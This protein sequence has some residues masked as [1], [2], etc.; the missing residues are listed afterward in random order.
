MALGFIAS[1]L[2]YG[3]LL[4]QATTPSQQSD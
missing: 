1:L 2:V 4:M 3:V